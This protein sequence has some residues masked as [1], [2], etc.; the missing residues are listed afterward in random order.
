[1]GEREERMKLGRLTGLCVSKEE[2]RLTYRGTQKEKKK[3]ETGA[4]S[5]LF[6]VLGLSLQHVKEGL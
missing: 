3:I 4:K 5:K 1:M 2:D 6:T